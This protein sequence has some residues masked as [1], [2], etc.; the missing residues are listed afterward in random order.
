MTARR[1]GR[2]KGALNKTTVAVKTA[3]ERA[4]D[5]TGGIDALIKWAK[6]NPAEFYKLWAKLLPVDLR[7]DLKVDSITDKLAERLDKAGA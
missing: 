1:T 6:A 3:L 2:P 5:G 4:F 7:A